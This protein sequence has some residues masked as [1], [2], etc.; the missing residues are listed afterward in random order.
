MAVEKLQ[1]QRPSYFLSHVNIKSTRN[2]INT[3]IENIKQLSNEK[4]FKNLIKKEKFKI[5]KD[6]FYNLFIDYAYTEEAL[7]RLSNTKDEMETL[8]EQLNTYLD[9]I[10][11]ILNFL[12]K[13]DDDLKFSNKGEISFEDE[14]NLD[15]YKKLYNEIEQ[16]T[17]E[18]NLKNAKEA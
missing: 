14:D 16:I 13:N 5:G 7:L 2:K 8:S 17:N 11:E 3:A 9:K 6:Y 15:N 18:F 12:Q 10:E 1:Q 4:K